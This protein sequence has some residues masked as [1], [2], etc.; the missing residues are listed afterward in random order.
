M[1]KLTNSLNISLPSSQNATNR[2]EILELKKEEQNKVK[3]DDISNAESG[4]KVV[5]ENKEGELMALRIS[6]ENYK[7]LQEHFS[8]YTNYIARDDN[9]IRLNGEVNEFV[10][11]WFEKISSAFFNPASLNNNKESEYISVNFHKKTTLESLQNLAFKGEDSLAKNANLEEKLNFALEKDVNLDGS[12]NE[13]DVKKQSLTEILRDLK[14]ASG[15]S[16]DASKM[17]D[18]QKK[19]ESDDKDKIKD[20]EEKTPLEKAL[21]EGLES[22]SQEEKAQLESS[23]PQKFKEL[24][25]QDLE[26][27]LSKDFKEQILRG[28]SP[29]VDKF[30]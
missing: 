4:F 7:N 8:S 6:E 13:F 3:V 17:Q 29:L 28:E 25:R 27:N 30:V 16:A 23:H 26:K 20:E 21:E 11:N 5:F 1:D 12:V 14:N 24:Q 2:K 18:T 10:A 15:E 19:V 22:L 9:S